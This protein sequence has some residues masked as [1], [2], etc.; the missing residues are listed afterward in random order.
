MLLELSNS[1]IESI[2]DIF[3]VSVNQYGFTESSQ[4]ARLVPTIDVIFNHL[5]FKFSEVFPPP[6][7]QLFL[8]QFELV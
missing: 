3:E 8:L 7:A 5:T 2:R 1:F 4:L 6:T